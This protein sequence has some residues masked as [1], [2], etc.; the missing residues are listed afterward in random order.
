MKPAAAAFPAQAGN[1]GERRRPEALASRIRGNGNYDFVTSIERADGLAH[2]RLYRPPPDRDHPG[3]GH[4][5][6]LRVLAALYRAGRSRGGRSPATSRPPRTSPASIASS[7]STSPSSCA[8]AMGLG[9]AAR[10][11][12]H[13]HLHQPAGDEAHRAAARA[14][15]RADGHD[16]HR[17]REL[18]HSAWASSPRAKVGSWIDRVGDG[19]SPCWASRCR[20][21]SSPIS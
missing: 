18:R 15:R 20:P 7:A 12:R 14:D 3:D 13:L 2:V 9:R 17:H 1:Q 5:G 6:A 21:S 16:A 10:R 4:R 8:S 11:P 19:A